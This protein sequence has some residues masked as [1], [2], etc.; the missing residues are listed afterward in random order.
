MHYGSSIRTSRLAIGRRANATDELPKIPYCA[1]G[2]AQRE[3]SPLRILRVYNHTYVLPLRAVCLYSC[4]SC[5]ID[6]HRQ[7]A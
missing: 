4:S 3:L 2:G 7:G 6:T 1:R 5:A